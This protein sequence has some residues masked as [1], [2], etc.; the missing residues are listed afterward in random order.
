MT[1][2][3]AVSFRNIPKFFMLKV[4]AFTKTTCILYVLY[5]ST[6]ATATR[7]LY[8]P[9]NDSRVYVTETGLNL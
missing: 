6:T 8:F 9:S 2:T 3:L 5:N 1:T 4:S 7:T